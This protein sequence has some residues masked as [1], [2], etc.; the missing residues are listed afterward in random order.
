MKGGLGMTLTDGNQVEDK[1]KILGNGLGI[2]VT[3]FG[4]TDVI[5][6]FTEDV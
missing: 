2:L 1:I 3:W 5:I 6:P 4:Q